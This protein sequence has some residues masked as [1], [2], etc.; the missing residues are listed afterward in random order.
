MEM[1]K[2]L[3][4]DIIFCMGWQRLIPEWLLNDLSVGAFGM[5]GSN[6]PLPHGRG[7]SPLNWSLIQDKNMFHLTS[8]RLVTLNL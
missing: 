6:K 7:R 5:H 4:I 1:I 3:N 8:I 2:S